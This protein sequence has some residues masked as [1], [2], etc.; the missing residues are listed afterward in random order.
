MIHPFLKA[1]PKINKTAFV[2]RSAE[3]IG[4]V[5]IGEEC[6]VWFNST[7]R[8]DVNFIVIGNRTNV[9]DNVCIHVTNQTAPTIIG[10]DVTIGHGAVIHGCTIKSRVLVGINSTILDNAVIQND[11]MIGAGSLVPPGKVLESGF[12]YFGSPVKKVRKLTE[13][14][15]EFLKKSANNYIRYS[16]AYTGK[17]V[18]DKNPFYDK[19]KPQ[20]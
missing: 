2:V 14:E 8:G 10:D 4:D 12:L 5:T 6:S 3:I 16:R 1:T 20:K 17:D 13:E 19:T 18:Y 7:I 11:V 9:Q 15:V